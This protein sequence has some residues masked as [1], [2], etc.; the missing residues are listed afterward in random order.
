MPKNFI[1]ILIMCII[2]CVI[3]CDNDV[4]YDIPKENL[5]SFVTNSKMIFVSKSAP[6]DTFLVNIRF[7]YVLSDKHNNY[8]EILINY[9]SIKQN[10][11]EDA[12]LLFIHQ[13][14]TGVY[15]TNQGNP[16]SNIQTLDTFQLVNG[17]E[18]KNVLVK[19]SSDQYVKEIK[20]LYYHYQY[21]VVKY[22]RKNGTA[23][24]LD[25]H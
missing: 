16:L 3:S 22:V 14:T 19:G 17:E 4:Y 1:I 21:G 12:R 10:Q 25:L 20:E 5:P 8:Q 2:L 13:N 7:D 18:I 9:Y 11:P 24:E 6:P 15:I 23:Y